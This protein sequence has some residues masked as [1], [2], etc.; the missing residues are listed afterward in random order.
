M[1]ASTFPQRIRFGDDRSF[2]RELT[3][4]VDRFFAETGLSKRDSAAFYSKAGILLVWTLT[5]YIYLVFCAQSVQQALIG[6][7]SLGLAS[8]FLAFNVYHDAS[9]N[10]ISRHPIVNRLG[11]W[12][13]NLVGTSSYVWVQRHIRM[14]HLYP[15][16]HD[17][18]C[19]INL[20]PVARITQYQ[21]HY[22]WHRL[23]HYYLWPLYGLYPFQW[24]YQQ[25]IEP[26]ITGK[27]GILPFP[28]P[29]GLDL[30][31]YLCGKVL[32]VGL[33]FALPLALHPIQ[34]VLIFYFIVYYINGLIF[35]VVTNIAHVT[36]GTDKPL[37][38]AEGE[39]H[40]AD[41]AIHQARVTSDFC[42]DNRVIS[43]L[44]GGL[45][46]QIEHHLFPEI[47]HTLYP[48][49]APIVRRTCQEYGVPY[50]YRRTLGGALSSHFEHLRELAGG[51]SAESAGRV[52]A[53]QNR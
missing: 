41:W 21:K 2:R 33:V 45:N 24:K 26:V 47:T 34:Y 28:R 52:P 20:G 53:R 18:D 38:P 44:L 8:L 22:F 14:H 1:N 23:Q 35:A 46:F 11:L 48:R 25:D 10:A 5:S 50:C 4:R 15:N 31:I 43:W 40:D 49:I 7:I 51:R 16:F 17:Y 36:T 12:M 9:H 30:F 37:P 29:K 39:R 13:M 27:L 3:H 6:S 42:H 19:D 32:Y